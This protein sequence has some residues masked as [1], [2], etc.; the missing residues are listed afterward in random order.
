MSEEEIRDICRKIVRIIVEQL[1]IEIEEDAIERIAEGLMNSVRAISFL[2]LSRANNLWGRL[3]YVER[4][5]RYRLPLDLSGK[6]F[7]V[8]SEDVYR[9]LQ[10]DLQ[11]Y[12]FRREI[13]PTEYHINLGELLEEKFELSNYVKRILLAGNV[14]RTL[15]I[16]SIALEASILDKLRKITKRGITVDDIEKFEY[17][18]GKW[19]G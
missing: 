19:F 13:R 10:Y 7:P 1:R 2:S 12:G 6:W 15:S 11:R 5:G 18:T 8:S 17:D 16:N 3:T 9:V 14:G 4:L